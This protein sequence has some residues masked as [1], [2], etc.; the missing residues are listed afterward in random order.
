MEANQLM[1]LMMHLLTVGRSLKTVK[2]KPSPFQMKQPILLPKFGPKGDLNL[3]EGNGGAGPAGEHEPLA[4]EQSSSADAA[5]AAQEQAVVTIG[6]PAVV[7]GWSSLRQAFGAKKGL[8]VQAEL[9]LEAV[10]VMRNDLREGGSSQLSGSNPF[11]A[12]NFP[13]TVTVA[14]HWW[15]RLNER[16]LARRRKQS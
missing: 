7:P 1:S 3:P 4:L 5:N 11:R 9:S 6:R 14:G 12:R 15:T 10:R 13:Q 16:L 8:M 2:D